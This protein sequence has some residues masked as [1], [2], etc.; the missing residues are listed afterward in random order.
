MQIGGPRP[1][2]AW[3]WAGMACVV[4]NAVVFGAANRELAG[5]GEWMLR[6]EALRSLRPGVVS[7]QV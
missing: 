4:R 3:P 2:L 6:Q 7:L 1:G 5:D